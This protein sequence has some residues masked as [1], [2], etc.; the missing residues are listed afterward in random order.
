MKEII[1]A[2]KNKGKVNEFNQL[3][4]LYG[5]TVK[6]LLDFEG[7]QFDVEETGK[8]FLENARL[9]AEQIS[10]LLQKP[11][12]ADDS[13]LEI[14]ALGG[15]P[16]VYSARYAGE[17]T[18]DKRNYDKV[19]TEMANVKQAERNARFVCVL[20]LAI[21]EKETVF[22]EGF[23]TGEIAQQP[24]GINGFGYDPIFIP[25]GFTQT[26]AELTEDEKNKI[27]HRYHAL[28]QM[29]AWLDQQMNQGDM[30]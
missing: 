13:G 24:A 1:I 6:S 17:P 19:L 30:R 18:D 21:P 8:T 26:M 4:S 11:V 3:F 23:C 25:T 12:L 16:G 27:S 28:I 20:A 9:K 10:K 29:K 14:D 15:D 7:T 22:K 2:T 5:I